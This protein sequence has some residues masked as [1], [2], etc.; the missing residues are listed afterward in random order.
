[1]RVKIKIFNSHISSE[2][3]NLDDKTI[4]SIKKLYG[5]ENV[6]L[7]EVEEEVNKWNT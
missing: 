4:E 6:E 5:E 3:Y 2:T 1:M 7:I